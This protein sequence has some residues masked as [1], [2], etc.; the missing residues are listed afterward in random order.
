[1]GRLAQT[2]GR[3]KQPAFQSSL[4][5]AYV[6]CVMT[7]LGAGYSF[8]NYYVHQ[9][10]VIPTIER[11]APPPADDTM[12]MVEPH[13]SQSVDRAALSSILRSRLDESSTL[14]REWVAL[15]KLHEQLLWNQ[16]VFWVIAVGAT[17]LVVTLLHRRKNA[18]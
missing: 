2:L 8:R 15:S 10:L 12:R 18:P 13:I 17:F 7:I 14:H 11:L 6:A 1:M 5:A 16:V 9:H 4:I 3:M